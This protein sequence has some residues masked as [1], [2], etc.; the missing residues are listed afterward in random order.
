MLRMPRASYSTHAMECL[1][2]D[3]MPNS[4]EIRRLARKWSGA[5]V[6]PK[7]LEWIEV[8]SIRGWTGQRVSFQFPI[9]AIVGE[10][11]SGKSTLLQA[12]ACVYRDE[13]GERTWFPSEFF[14][15]TAWDTITGVKIPYGYQEGQHHLEGA[16]RKPTTRW[17]GHGER[18][19]RHVE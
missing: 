1:R 17:L 15:E 5:N 11:G 9:V 13:E 18:P 14:P 12:A 3:H 19:I 2:S 10:N 4:P 16:V 7:R 8:D 6:W